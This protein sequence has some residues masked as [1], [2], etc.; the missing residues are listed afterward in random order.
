MRSVRVFCDRASALQF[1][2]EQPGSV[3]RRVDDN[4]P[5]R[6]FGYRWEVEYQGPV[7]VPGPSQGEEAR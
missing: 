1:Q 6:D 2:H 4:N 5:M 7:D 3:L